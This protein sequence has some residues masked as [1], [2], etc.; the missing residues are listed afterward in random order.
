MTFAEKALAVFA[1]KGFSQYDIDEA[2]QM[3]REAWNIPHLKECWINWIDE[4]FKVWR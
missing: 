2:K 3:I 1:A 4:E